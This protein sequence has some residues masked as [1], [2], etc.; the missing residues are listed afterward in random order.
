MNA[1]TGSDVSDVTEIEMTYEQLEKIV[2]LKVSNVPD[3][4]IARGFGFSEKWLTELYETEEYKECFRS[5]FEKQ[6]EELDAVNKG[7]DGIE[8][9]ALKRLND[10]LRS[11]FLDPEFALKIAAVANKAQRRNLIGNKPIEAERRGTAVIYI[12]GNFVEKMQ[13][14]QVTERNHGSAGGDMKQND[15]VDPNAVENIL[16]GEKRQVNS[17]RHLDQEVMDILAGGKTMIMA[18]EK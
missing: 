18:G 4:Q 15:F 13:T 17:Q 2:L 8:A 11:N 1:V 10:E 5:H 7:W 16:L 6:V 3:D 12:K 14:L 9:T